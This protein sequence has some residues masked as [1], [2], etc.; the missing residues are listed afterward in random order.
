MTKVSIITVN[1]NNCKGLIKTIES[2][3]AQSFI[4]YE[5][6]I[7]DGGSNDGSKELIAKYESKLAYWVSEKDNGIYHAMNKGIRHATGE[8]LIFLNSGDYFYSN[9]VLKMIDDDLS[10]DGIIYGNMMIDFGLEK[11]L[12]IYPDVL[13]FAYFLKASL[14]HPATFIHKSVFNKTGLFKEDNTIV[15]DWEFFIT[16]FSFHQATYKHVDLIVSGFESTGISSTTESVKVILN[17]KQRILYRDFK[18]FLDD[19][20]KME[21]NEESLKTAEST[22]Q[23]YENSRLRRLANKI[24]KFQNRTF[25]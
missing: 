22:I 14:P 16:S 10:G 3:F 25:F 6:I 5:Y 24:K 4:H 17:E 21:E 20:K 18:F 19:Y 12:K 11:R 2:V 9:E 8:Y 13:T 7:I 1:K 15:S 23:L